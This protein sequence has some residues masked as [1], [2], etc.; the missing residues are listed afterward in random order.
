[1][2]V[3]GGSG[4]RL[5]LTLGGGE[6]RLL[7]LTAAYG[8][9]AAQGR[10]VQPALILRI[11][12]RDGNTV[13]DWQML[14]PG[15]NV[16]DPR[17]AYL[18]TDILSD[19]NA[20]LPSFGDHS[21]LQIGRPAAAKTGTTTDFRDNWTLGYTPDLVVGVRVGNADNSPMVKVS[22]ISGAGPIWNEFMRTVL[23]GSPKRWFERPEGMTEAEVC[24]VSGLKPTPLCPARKV[25]LYSD[26]TIPLT[27][28]TM[29]RAFTLDCATG[30]LATD[31]TPPDRRIER[32]YQILP[33]E[34]QDWAAHHGIERPPI[35]V[36]SSFGLGA[37]QAN[38]LR[39]L[40]PDPYTVTS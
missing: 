16:F 6:I 31:S 9:F 40:M 22:G 14:E 8:A 26:G 23:K 39:M 10:A 28:D 35:A 24:A 3:W 12:D 38:E 7:D 27:D 4:G 34:A 5:S 33:Q 2:Q 1:M 32:V 36:E 20:R 13:Y 30:L 15:D 11:S 17:V 21:P 37:N 29:F 25:D 18:I 19:D